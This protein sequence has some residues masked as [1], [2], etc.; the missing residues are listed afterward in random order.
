MNQLPP[1]RVSYLWERGG[2]GGRGGG[3]EGGVRGSGFRVQVQGSA[4][5]GIESARKRE[6]REGV[7]ETET[8]SEAG[9]DALRSN[10]RL[11]G[12]WG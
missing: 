5:T 2:E 11:L 3:G 6:E 10:E 9:G 4:F 12:V 7:R 1:R 8:E